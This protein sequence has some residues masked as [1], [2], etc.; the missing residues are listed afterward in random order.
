MISTVV[1]HNK[2]IRNRMFSDTSRSWKLGIDLSV[3]RTGIVSQ[4][5]KKWAQCRP[6][7]FSKGVDPGWGAGGRGGKMG[8]GA[9]GVICSYHGGAI[10]NLLG[11]LREVKLAIKSGDHSNRYECVIG[12]WFGFLCPGL[13]C[14]L[15]HKRIDTTEPLSQR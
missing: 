5:L 6:C 12:G 15:A 10:Y 11:K 2:K 3:R 7:P 14:M 8:V 4:S 1:D 13:Q 9:R